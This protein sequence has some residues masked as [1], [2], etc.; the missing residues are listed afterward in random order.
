MNV[1]SNG[2]I[3]RM[4]VEN[5]T[6]GAWSAIAAVL[7]GERVGRDASPS[8]MGGFYSQVLRDTVVVGPHGEWIIVDERGDFVAAA[9]GARE[10]EHVSVDQ[11]LEVVRAIARTPEGAG[12]LVTVGGASRDGRTYTV[13]VDDLAR[14]RYEGPDVAAVAVVVTTP[15]GHAAF[16]LTPPQRAQLTGILKQRAWELAQLQGIAVGQVT[17]GEFVDAYV[18]GDHVS[19]RASGPWTVEEVQS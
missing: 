5:R 17:L 2:R 7:S 1:T 13:V 12:R 6:P 4:L 8:P 10:L 14:G 9:E 16:K 3:A 11:V 19:L 15:E 18:A